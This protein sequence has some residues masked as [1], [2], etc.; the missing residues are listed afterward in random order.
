MDEYTLVVLE[1]ERFIVVR[2][3]DCTIAVPG[4]W[5]FIEVQ[6]NGTTR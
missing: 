4:E 3:E 6:G 2:E 1:E 5:R